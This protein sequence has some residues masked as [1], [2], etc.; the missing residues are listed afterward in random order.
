MLWSC[1]AVK[2]KLLKEHHLKYFASMKGLSLSEYWSSLP[3]LIFVYSPTMD[4]NDNVRKTFHQQLSDLLQN[5]LPNDRLIVPGNFNAK[6]GKDK[7]LWE[8]LINQESETTMKISP[9]S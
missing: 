4:V 7:R 8:N 6:L 3:P 1:F 2:S 9:S 5:V